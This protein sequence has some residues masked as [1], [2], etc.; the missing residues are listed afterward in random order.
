MELTNI[1]RMELRG[2]YSYIIKVLIP[3]MAGDAADEGNG[4][5]DD[6]GN[7]VLGG[8]DYDNDAV[9]EGNERNRRPGGRRWPSSRAASREAER[10]RRISS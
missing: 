8:D 4:L 7:V 3:S 5:N 9:D 6:D 2:L 10:R 1:D